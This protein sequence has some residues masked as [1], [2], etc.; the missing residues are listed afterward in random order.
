[1][2]R[3]VTTH[4]DWGEK[5]MS[6]MREKQ[7]EACER[8]LSAH[9]GLSL[10]CPQITDLE[11]QELMEGSYYRHEMGQTL[12][13]VEGL[14]QEVL[15]QLPREALCLSQGE[16]QL[17][18]RLLIADGS[19]A[20]TEW[21]DIGAAEALVSRLW[22]S[23]RMTEEDWM[24][25][26]PKALHEPILVAMNSAEYAQVKELLF[27][28]DAMM[29]GLL[30]IAGFLHCA[31]PIQTFTRDVIGHSDRLSENLARRYLKSS[32]EYMTDSSNQM[33][34]LHPGLADP[35]RLIAAV[36]SDELFTLEL[37]QEMM[38]GG[39]N[40]LFPEE[41]PLHEAMCGALEGSLRPEYDV[42]EATEDLRMLAKQGVS[43]EEMEAVM[44]SMLCVVPTPDMKRALEQLHQCTPH[45]IGLRADLQ[46]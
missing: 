19:I 15:R 7:F 11:V 16:S 31:Q 17:V 46:H 40:G 28:Y 5:T 1:M 14:R 35:Y 37:S 12:V 41:E 36:N 38:A 26:L 4:S 3:E 18:E 45:W 32:F 8:R 22:C 43:L 10:F 39:M 21:D 29:M 24:L 33:I 44:A 20:L 42:A 30:Y 27:R 13:T 34:L 23:F 9:P 6:M 25:E 2:L